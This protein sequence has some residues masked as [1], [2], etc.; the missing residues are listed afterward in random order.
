M[1]LRELTVEEMLLVA[2]GEGEGNGGDSAGTGSDGANGGGSESSG[3][4]G[5]EA[6]AGAYGVPDP[7]FGP[8]PMQDQTN[9]NMEVAAP[10]TNDSM[11]NAYGRGGPPGNFNGGPGFPDPAH[12]DAIDGIW[13]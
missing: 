7:G 2:G 12:V 5:N 8:G 10:V 1:G 4:G 3:D 9:D 13:I 11:D 6:G